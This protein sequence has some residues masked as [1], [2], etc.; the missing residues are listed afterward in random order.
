MSSRAR[1]LA[2]KKKAR[3]LKDQAQVEQDVAIEE[4]EVEE[5]EVAE[6]KDYGMAEMPMPGPTSFAELDEKR[7][8]DDK[9]WDVKSVLMDAELISHNIFQSPTM[10]YPEKAGKLKEL[11]TA[12][13]AKMTATVNKPV[14]KEFDFDLAEIEML[15]NMDTAGL[16][17]NTV[18]IF[19]RATADESKLTDTDFAVVSGEGEAKVRQF[20]IH[21]AAHVR[22][23]LSMAAHKIK[24]GDEDIAAIKA[25]LPKVFVAAHRFGIGSP[26]EKNPNA[27][28]VLKDK[29]GS[30]RWFGWVSNNFKDR[31]KQ[32]ITDEAHKDY[33]N[34]LDAN[35]KFAPTFRIWHTKG[36]DRE[37]QADWWDYNNGFLMM[38]GPLN[39]KEAV[40][41]VKAASKQKL[42]MSHGFIGT[43]KDN[44]EINWY[45]T[46][47]VSDLPV[48]YASNP[49]TSMD[50]L[51]K[52][53]AMNKVKAE[54]I[55]GQLGEDFVKAI[56]AESATKQ[57]ELRDAG[58]EEKDAKV[59]EKLEDEKKPEAEKKEEEKKPDTKEVDLAAVLAAVSKEYGLPELSEWVKTAQASIAKV[60][61]LEKQ[62]ADLTKSEDE[63]IAEKITPPA[64][65]SYMAWMERASESKEN[66]VNG[67]ED[68]E[69]EKDATEGWFAR[70]ANNTVAPIQ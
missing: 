61:A 41:L 10:E 47:E 3:L 16:V 23:S 52:E 6:E 50:V 21:T 56:E 51:A 53:K 12:F 44:T 22:K 36:T 49:W 7:A 62:I 64:A 67:E 48:D 17:E 8:Q 63:K 13:V 18:D 69:L 34:W 25:A 42:G 40:A 60:D 55:G 66:V 38:S 1:I 31:D 19:E 68:A 54:Y 45:R 14:A 33:M 46:F 58:I 37:K 24:A 29:S 43:V 20:P 11:G 59:E 70:V 15:Q 5:P 30:F 39:E 26:S 57:A 4:S 27:I 65:K 35:P 9:E 28:T 2:R 32:I